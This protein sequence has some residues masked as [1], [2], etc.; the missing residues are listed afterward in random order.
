[1][2]QY[3]VKRTYRDTT[4][5][6]RLGAI[7]TEECIVS[8]SSR[9]LRPYAIS[10]L[11]NDITG[12]KLDKVHHFAP[13]RVDIFYGAQLQCTCMAPDYVWQVY[14]KQNDIYGWYDDIEQ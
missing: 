7:T 3:V 13:H 4:K 9:D 6:N 5:I 2:E 12:Y 14:R 1:M 10:G 11:R 8:T